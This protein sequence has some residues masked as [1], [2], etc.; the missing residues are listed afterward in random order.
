ME[1]FKRLQHSFQ[2]GNTY[3]V[4]DFFKVAAPFHLLIIAGS[5]ICKVR[6]TVVAI[7][8]A[9]RK[10]DKSL[11]YAKI[12]TLSLDRAENFSYR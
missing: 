2:M 12:W 8:V 4:L 9:T 5:R 1:M 6:I 3:R 10:A 11:P 7:E